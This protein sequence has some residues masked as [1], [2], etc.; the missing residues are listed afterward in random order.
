MPL[1]GFRQNR[2]LGAAWKTQKTKCMESSIL[3]TQTQSNS[4]S[5]HLCVGFLFLILYPGSASSRPASS[6]P[7][8]VFVNHLSH[9]CQP[10]SFTPSLSTTIFVN[11]HLSPHLCQPPSFTHIFVNH[12]SHTIFQTP[13][14]S[15]TIFHPIFV[16]HHLCQPPFFTPSLSTTIFHTHL[17]QP[18]FT[19]HLSHTIFVNHHLSPH[20]CQPPSFPHIFV[21][22]L[23]D[24][25]FVNHHLSPHLCQPP[26]L[27]TTIFH[28]IFVNHH[29]SHTSLSTIFHKPSFR[30][31]L[32]QPPS[33]TVFVN[34]LCQP[35]LSTTIFHHLCQPSLS[36]I[37]V[38]QHIS[39]TSLPTTCHTPSFTHHLC[40]VWQAWH[41]E[42]STLVLRG[43]RGTWRHPPWFCV[44][45]V[46][47]MALGWLWWRAWACFGRR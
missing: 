13:S 34:H 29:L 40:L 22:H 5:P 35:S 14:L 23:S 11:H 38:N 41:L 18:S 42:T 27:S 26:S 16:N 10:P 19:H 30:H 31:H 3:K 24:T 28:P 45:G 37:F 25:I 6:L 21:N 39:H 7:P 9:L 43:R 2:Q 17:C 12:L 36:T 15:T 20:L 47:L 4:F 33:F 1:R 44:A 32:C 46:A 8:P